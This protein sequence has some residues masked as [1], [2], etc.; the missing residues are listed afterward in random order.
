MFE[1]PL[2]HRDPDGHGE[3]G[4]QRGRAVGALRADEG[5]TGG[6]G[7]ALWRGAALGV[8]VAD[9]KQRVWR[10]NKPVYG[11]AQAGRRWQRTLFP[12]LKEWGLKA[13]ESDN[14]VFFLKRTVETPA[15]PR[16]DT[17]IVGC[18]VDDLFILYNSDDE[19]S[20]YHQFT[21]D[22][23]KRWSV[24]DE[25]DVKSSAW[26]FGECGGFECYIAA[27]EEGDAA[28]TA[29]AA[30]YKAQGEDDEDELLS[31][32]A[33]GEE[34]F[35]AVLAHDLTAMREAYEAKLARAHADAREAAASHRREIRTMQDALDRERR[36][37]DA[38]MRTATRAASG[39]SSGAL[40]AR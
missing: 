38:R 20:S 39:T 6:A 34:S 26:D 11:M 12:W 32:S 7:S 3:R 18:Y 8:R 21:R 2:P 33:D 4:R 37:A 36:A 16:E 40:T 27:D 25:G 9:G 31:V 5:G 35:E 14:C 15:G 24:D 13:C 22:L 17:L 1:H 29:T 28:N 30:V 10:V 19:Y 23:Q